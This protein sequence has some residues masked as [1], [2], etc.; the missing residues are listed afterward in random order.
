MQFFNNTQPIQNSTNTKLKDNSKSEIIAIVNQKGGVGK[1]TSTVN[2]AAALARLEHKVLLIDFDPQG[3]AS[4]YLG[5]NITTLAKTVLNF[6]EGEG[7]NSIVI[8]NV[9]TNLD[10]LPANLQLGSYNQGKSS[11]DTKSLQAQLIK[12]GALDHYEYILI[13]CQP[14]LSNLT[15][16]A[17]SASTSLVIPMQA[18]YL[19]LDG[20]SQLL[21]TLKQV[22]QKLNPDLKILGILITMYDKRNKLCQEVRE[23]LVKNMPQELFRTVITRLVRLAESP[24]HGKTIFEY[25]PTGQAS[26]AYYDFAREVIERSQGAE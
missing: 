13:D 25:D 8:Q 14:S 18:E 11:I 17:M 22:K 1:T 23:E 24:S 19:A 20:L 4:S 21:L 6:V 7:I 9:R 15:I 16:N 3:N 2:L 5:I 26:L 12:S 10:L